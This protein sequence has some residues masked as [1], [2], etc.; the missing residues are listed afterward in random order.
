MGVNYSPKI[1][2]AFGIPFV[3]CRGVTK[4][5][6]LLTYLDDFPGV[7]TKV[8]SL[9]GSESPASYFGPPIFSSLSCCSSWPGVESLEPLN[10]VFYTSTVVGFSPHNTGGRQLHLCSCNLKTS[11]LSSGDKACIQAKTLAYDLTPRKISS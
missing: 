6:G 4:T 5:M 1:Q 3:D 10:F 9:G 2:P 11:A 8:G 7:M